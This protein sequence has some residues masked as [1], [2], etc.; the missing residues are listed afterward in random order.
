MSLIKIR[1]KKKDIRNYLSLSNVE[2]KI[3]SIINI[4]NV[5]RT[6]PSFL[7][8]HCQMRFTVSI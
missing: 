4:V 3:K 5:A 7:H 1:V 2:H 6:K 8:A